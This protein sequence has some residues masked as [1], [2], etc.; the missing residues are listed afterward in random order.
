MALATARERT[1]PPPLGFPPRRRS[2]FTQEPQTESRQARQLATPD[3]SRARM[4]STEL[5]PSASKSA[6]L[7]GAG[8]LPDH[9]AVDRLTVA[10]ELAHVEDICPQVADSLQ[11]MLELAA[12]KPR[13]RH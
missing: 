1:P 5:A 2:Y 11:R 12:I 8:L 6:A 4:G 10:V 3:P 7:G 13:K 9:L